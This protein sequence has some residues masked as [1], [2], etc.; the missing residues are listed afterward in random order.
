MR[1][2]SGENQPVF[3]ERHVL[4]TGSP[5]FVA[6]R[7]LW[8]ICDQEPDTRVTLI[9]RR[10]LIERTE[11]ALARRVGVRSRV[12]VIPGDVVA[13]R[14]GLSDRAFDELVES[15]TDIYHLASIYHLGVDKRRAEEVNIQGTRHMLDT[16][17]ACPNLVRLN[18][19]STAFVSGD[20]EGV[21]MESELERGQHFRNT[22][23]RTKFTAEL[24]VRRAFGE[25]PISIFR[26]SL[27]VGDSVTGEID[28][29]DGPYFLLQL[30]ALNPTRLPVPI[31]SSSSYPLNVVPVNFVAEA[32]H[33]ISLNPWAE[34]KTFHLVDPNPVS[35]RDA[36]RMVAEHARR[37]APRG[38]M[39]SWLSRR[40]MELPLVERFH[41]GEPG[42]PP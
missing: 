9:V 18:H 14:L 31:P 10:D 12:D 40:L 2:T 33:V 8:S 6:I 39:P 24:E 35:S 28:R 21:I 20:R 25:L 19:Y 11:A 38:S 17:R 34:G 16:A 27:V 30:I 29:L 26:P 15:V 1:Q 5:N 13:K 23:E 42:I 4:I 32:M 36:F 37:K 3:R 41:A 22:F 7:L